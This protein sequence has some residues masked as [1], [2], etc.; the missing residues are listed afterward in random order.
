MSQERAS[1]FPTPEGGVA[2]LLKRRAAKVSE[3]LTPELESS[4]PELY[5][6]L[7][8]LVCGV[9]DYDLTEQPGESHELLLEN[10]EIARDL[11]RAAIRAGEDPTDVLD[12]S[13]DNI[14]GFI[15]GRVAMVVPPHMADPERVARAIAR[16]QELAKEYG[17]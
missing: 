16:G 10:V 8:W 17:W 1:L 5:D 7:Y 14:R 3:C 11:A 4:H 9:T 15:Q 2:A 12:R 6:R 13:L